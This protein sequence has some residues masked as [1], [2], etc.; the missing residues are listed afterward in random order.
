MKT[1]LWTLLLSAVLIGV[2]WIPVMSGYLSARGPL[3][4][5]TYRTASTTTPPDWV[6]RAHLNAVENIAPFAVVLLR[7]AM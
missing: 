7:H 6:N 1:A 3:T 4:P 5:A 2:L